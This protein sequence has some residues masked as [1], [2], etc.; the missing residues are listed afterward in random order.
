MIRT[1]KGR[2][3]KIDPDAFVHDSAVVTGDVEIRAGASVWP[4][5]VIR[6]DMAKVV[7]GENT[8]VQDNSVLHTNEGLPLIIEE[9]VLIAHNANLHSCTIRKNASIGIAAIVLDGAE[10]GEGAFIAAGALVTPGRKIPAGM[11]AKGHP[12][13]PAR[14]VKPEEQQQHDDLVRAYCEDAKAYKETEKDV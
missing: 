6:G 3:P 13:K 8:N 4:C 14:E 1:V 11:L 9:N 7:V 5:A 12:A 10:V 2:T